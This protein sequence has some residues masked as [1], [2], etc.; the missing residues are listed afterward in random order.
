M[1]QI[2]FVQFLASS[3]PS[4]GRRLDGGCIPVFCRWSCCT[5]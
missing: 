5:D 2:T 4:Y 1:L 3:L